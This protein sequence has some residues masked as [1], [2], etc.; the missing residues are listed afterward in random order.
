MLAYPTH[1][2]SRSGAQC[3]EARF[4]RSLR[5][6]RTTLYHLSR[7]GRELTT[8]TPEPLNLRRRSLCY[9]LRLSEQR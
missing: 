9:E 2:Q 3:T 6:Q 4:K 1:N 8:T 5:Y 7:D